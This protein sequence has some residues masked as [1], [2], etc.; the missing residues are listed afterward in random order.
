[1]AASLARD[2]FCRRAEPRPGG[3]EGTKLSA[4]LREAARAEQKPFIG[5]LLGCKSMERLHLLEARSPITL[6]ERVL[7]LRSLIPP[8]RDSTPGIPSIIITTRPQQGERMDKSS[9]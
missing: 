4:C 2:S 9:K 3:G 7:R 8:G 5:E 1:M 6:N